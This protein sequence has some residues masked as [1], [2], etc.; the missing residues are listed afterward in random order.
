M[1]DRPGHLSTLDWVL[2]GDKR[3]HGQQLAAKPVAAASQLFV[4]S[5]FDT[6]LGKTEILLLPKVLESRTV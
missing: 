2:Q 4:T 1:K 5:G 3:C 6:H